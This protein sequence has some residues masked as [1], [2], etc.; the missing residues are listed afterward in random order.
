MK[1]FIDM[2]N[3]KVFRAK[4]IFKKLRRKSSPVSLFPLKKY[5]YTF[6]NRLWLKSILIITDY[7]P[8]SSASYCSFLRRVHTHF[9]QTRCCSR[10]FLFHSKEFLKIPH[11]PFRMG[12]LFNI[13]A[14]NPTISISHE[15]TY[16]CCSALCH[17]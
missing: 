10:H 17:H 8:S 4:T 15:S 6:W 16:A 5:T 12:H 2:T 11:G 3:Q 14:L 13:I 1:C 9:C 7:N